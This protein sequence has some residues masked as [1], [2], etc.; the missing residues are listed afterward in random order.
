MNSLKPEPGSSI[1]IYG[2][3]A[4]GLSAVM[5]ANLLGLKNI[6]VI[7]IHENR[8]ELAKEL[9]AAHALK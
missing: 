8:L 9:G 3:G 6:I 7:D 5:A 2:A 4:V 1:A